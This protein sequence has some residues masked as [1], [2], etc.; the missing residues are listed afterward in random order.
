MNA[1]RPR[2]YGPWSETGAG[3]WMIALTSAVALGWMASPVAAQD[4]LPAFDL[5]NGEIPLTIDVAAQD[6]ACAVEGDLVFSAVIAALEDGGLTWSRFYD[7]QPDHRLRVQIRI[8]DTG[9]NAVCSGYLFAAFEQAADIALSF[10]DTRHQ[11]FVT[12]IQYDGAL[13]FAD[14]TEASLTERVAD[15]VYNTLRHAVDLARSEDPGHGE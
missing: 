6:E 10:S 9:Q 3:R 4:Q 8:F 5:L 7:T 12:L 1:S 14:T 11:D 13:V 2:D 15:Q